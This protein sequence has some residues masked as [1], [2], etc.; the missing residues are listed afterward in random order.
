MA[1]EKAEVRISAVPFFDRHLKLWMAFFRRIQ[2]VLRRISEQRT[3]R[4]TAMELGIFR[5]YCSELSN[6][7]TEP[8]F[9][10]VG[11]NDGVSD[12]PCSDIL[13]NDKQ[14][15]GLLI[16]PVPYCFERLKG[17]FRDLRRF[18]LEQVAVGTKAGTAI[19]Y[20]V[21]PKIVDAQPRPYIPPW[22][23]QLGS[24]NREHII[25][26]GIE[27][28]FILEDTVQVCTLS[29]LIKKNGIREIHLLQ[30][31]TEGNDYEVLKSLD[32]TAQTPLLIFVEHVHLPKDQ[33]R[34]MVDLL[35]RQGYFIRDCGRDYLAI[36]KKAIRQLKRKIL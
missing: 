25:K 35:R 12:D 5:Y 36:N 17:N 21:D 34:E 28:A 14:W 16:E 4:K 22:F 31:D 32:F 3:A 2:R 10:K 19:F 20:Y 30:I 13:L 27:A 9:V 33:K 15:R 29:S 6:L 18:S 7:V 24:F 1:F 26:H 8:V 23:N 11:A